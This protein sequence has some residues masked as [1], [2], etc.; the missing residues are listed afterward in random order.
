MNERENTTQEFEN[1]TDESVSNQDAASSVVE[2]NDSVDETLE[3]AETAE[4]QAEPSAETEFEAVCKQRDEYL[5]DLQRLQAEFDNFRK[6]TIRERSEMREFLLQEF[7]GR[8]LDVIDNLDR[9]LNTDSNEDNHESFRDG[10]KMIQQQMMTIL[11]EYGLER[12]NTQG[13]MF[14]PSVHEAM[15]LIESEEHQPGQIVSEFMPG[16]LLK[17][18]VLRAAKVQVAQAASTPSDQ[19]ETNES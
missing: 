2:E 15:M 17:E 7:M 18:R 13:E 11:S 14:D 16:Y 12:I 5:H 4:G 19:T 10:V 3:E 9:A 1:P 6:R 8:L